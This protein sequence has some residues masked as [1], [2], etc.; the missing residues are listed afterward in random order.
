MLRESNAAVDVLAGAGDAAGSAPASAT[1][2]NR[3]TI[4]DGIKCGRCKWVRFKFMPACP[5]CSYVPPLA[6]DTSLRGDVMPER[7]RRQR[8]SVGDAA[9][10]APVHR[11]GVASTDARNDDPPPER[12]LFEAL[13]REA[14]ECLA[15]RGVLSSA[16]GAGSRASKREW[17]RRQAEAWV[18]SNARTPVTAFVP[19]CQ[20]LGL[21]PEATRT[22]LLHPEVSQRAA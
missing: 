20:A 3:R 9:P 13:L 6:F 10:A 14:I 5:K 15:G 8:A 21:D 2:T 4:K 16:E 7:P 17:L 19:V 12:E 22:V 1:P 11:A 18:F